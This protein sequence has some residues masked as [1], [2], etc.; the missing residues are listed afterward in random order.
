MSAFRFKAGLVA[1][2]AFTVSSERAS[3]DETP[4]KLKV[5]LSQNGD[6]VRA[7]FD[8]SETFT[9]GFR[10]RLGGGL[11][12]RVL[13]EMTLLDPSEE[14]IAVELRECQL[15]FD[16]W[17]DVL[18][19]Q[20][21]SLDGRKRLRLISIDDGLR[22]C[23]QVADAYLTDRSLL[24]RKTGYRVQVIVALNPVSPELLRHTREFLAN[25]RGNRSG[26]PRTFF[27]AISHLFS[28]GQEA[29]GERFIFLSS[30]LDRPGAQ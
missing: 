29:G 20:I 24:T 15:R 9:A 27:G 19:V 8:V 7:S 5:S 16:I 26:R 4:Q 10:R 18:L 2:F 11:T 22:A 12:S 21:E 25:P 28:S 3:A 14:P 30:A 1:L 6:S 17:D 23:G 13:I